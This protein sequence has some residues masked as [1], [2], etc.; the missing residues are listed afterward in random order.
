MRSAWYLTINHAEL[1]WLWYSTRFLVNS[2][3]LVIEPLRRFLC[4]TSVWPIWHIHPSD[5]F[6]PPVERRHPPTQCIVLCFSMF[7]MWIYASRMF[8][9][10]SNICLYIPRPHFKFLE[11]TLHSPPFLS[12]PSQSILGSNKTEGLHWRSNTPLPFP[13]LS[14]GK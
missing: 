5:I 9:P 11:I 1:V 8:T 6:T 4:Y 7:L 2:C 13:C 3:F 12:I 14:M 10:P